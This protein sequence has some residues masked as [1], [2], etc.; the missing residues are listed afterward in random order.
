MGRTED[1]PTCESPMPKRKLVS[2]MDLLETNHVDTFHEP[3]QYG[4]LLGESFLAVGG[5]KKEA[6][7]IPHRTFE[8]ER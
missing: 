4:A 2:A 3:L 5:A 6:T 8:G 1:G 7:N